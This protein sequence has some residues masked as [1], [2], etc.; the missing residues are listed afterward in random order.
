[1][2]FKIF[3]AYTNLNCLSAAERQ[4]ISKNSKHNMRL[5]IVT[6]PT[7]SIEPTFVNFF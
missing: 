6:A 5:S 7:I 2:L 4:S 3:L 1:M